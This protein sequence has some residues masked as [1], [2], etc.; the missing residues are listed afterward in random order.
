M[1][2]EKTNDDD[3]ERGTGTW[4]SPATAKSGKSVSGKFTLKVKISKWVPFENAEEVIV[5]VDKKNKTVLI[6]SL[7][8]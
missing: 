7:G 1:D 8:N 5:E 6:K 3:I 2:N 4:Y